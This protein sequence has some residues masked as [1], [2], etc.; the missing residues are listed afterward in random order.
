MF[1]L[2]R[3]SRE[4]LARINVAVSDDFKVVVTDPALF[5][6]CDQELPKEMC[7]S[8]LPITGS[9]PSQLA[10][11]LLALLFATIAKLFA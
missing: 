3:S 10:T 2:S 11:P 8:Q 4:E 5:E 7:Q 6:A 9:A 1:F